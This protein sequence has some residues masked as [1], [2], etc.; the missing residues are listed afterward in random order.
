[1]QQIIDFVL[2]NLCVKHQTLSY[3]NNSVPEKRLL[4][5]SVNIILLIIDKSSF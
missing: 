4:E 3:P 1:M 5:L 2:F